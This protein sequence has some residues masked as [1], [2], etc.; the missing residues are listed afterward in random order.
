MVVGFNV[1]APSKVQQIAGQQGVRLLTE[2]VI[3]KLMDEIKQRVVELLPVTYEQ[4]VLGEATVQEIFTIALKGRSSMN[5]AGCRIVNGVIA[6]NAKVRVMREGVQVYDGEPF[7]DL[8]WASFLEFIVHVGSRLYRDAQAAEKGHVRD[9]QGQRVRDVVYKIPRPQGGRPHP[10]I[11]DDREAG[12]ALDLEI[13]RFCYRSPSTTSHCAH[14]ICV[15][16]S[17][18]SR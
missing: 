5:I 17:R 14:H 16:Q 10:D 9:A 1:N 3:Y 7:F 12:R 4:R 13:T 18:V 2:N 11:R 6:K 8:R 15:L